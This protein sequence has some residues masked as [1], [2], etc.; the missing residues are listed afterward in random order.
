MRE[1]GTILVAYY[2]QM[3]LSVRSGDNTGSTLSA[4]AAMREVGD[5]FGSTLS[6]NAAVREKGD[7]SDSTLSANAIMCKVGVISGCT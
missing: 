7:K 6:A 4:N 1:T 5:I 2:P 3:P